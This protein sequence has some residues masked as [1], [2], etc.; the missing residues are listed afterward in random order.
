M[1]IKEFSIYLKDRVISQDPA[2]EEG[3]FDPSDFAN[4][5]NY[6]EVEF[7]TLLTGLFRFAKHYIKKAFSGSSLRTIDEFGFLATLLSEGS[8]LKN[9]LINH[10]HLE[11]SSGSEILKRLIRNGLVQENQDKND[12]R[13]KRVSLTRKGKEEIFKAFEDM[14]RVSEIVIGNLN[15]KELSDALSIFNKLTYFHKHIQEEDKKSGLEEL[16][17][18]YIVEDVRASNN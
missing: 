17:K 16:H 11:I 7:S 18:K 12:K 9:E 15:K 13:A 8:L 6:P 5:R 1:N 14:H 4:Y 10:H 3:S 2:N